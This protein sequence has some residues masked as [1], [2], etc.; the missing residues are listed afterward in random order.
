MNNRITQK[1]DIPSSSHF[2]IIVFD[3]ITEDNGRDKSSRKVTNIHIFQNEADFVKA[4]NEIENDDK[5]YI[6]KTEYVAQRVSGIVKVQTRIEVI[7][8]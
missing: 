8:S 4:I 1:T 3:T 5:K 2:Q 6:R 7:L